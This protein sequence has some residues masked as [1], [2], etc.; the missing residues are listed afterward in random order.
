MKMR[1]RYHDGEVN[2]YDLPE[3]FDAARFHDDLDRCA[4]MRKFMRG[5]HAV[6]KNKSTLPVF[7][8]PHWIVEV[9]IIP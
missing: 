4:G 9:R 5:E 8:N 6:P 3:S 1:V 2:V 7:I